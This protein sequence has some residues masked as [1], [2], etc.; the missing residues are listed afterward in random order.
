[1]LRAMKRQKLTRIAPAEAVDRLVHRI[2]KRVRSGGSAEWPGMGKF[3]PGDKPPI[4]F[5]PDKA[6][7][8]VE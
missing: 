7:G 2:L 4:S 3:S 8:K 5:K 1:M 6:K